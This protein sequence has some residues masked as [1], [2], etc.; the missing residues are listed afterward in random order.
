MNNLTNIA[1]GVFILFFAIYTGYLIQLSLSLKFQN[2]CD[3]KYGEDN[4]TTIESPR[5]SGLSVV[6]V[7]IQKE[8]DKK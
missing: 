8:E 4:W 6:H 7:C 2:D 5:I 3:L 1:V